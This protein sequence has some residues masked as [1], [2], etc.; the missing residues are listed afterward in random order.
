[1]GDFLTNPTKAWTVRWKGNGFDY[2]KIKDLFSA[3]AIID[4]LTR[5]W[6]RYL[7]CLKVKNQY[8]GCKRNL[9]QAVNKRQEFHEGNGQRIWQATT[10]LRIYTKRNSQSVQ[11]LSSVW[12]FVTPWTAAHQASLSMTNSWCLLKLMSIKS[13]MPSNH[14]ILCHP[15]FSWLQFFPAS[16]SFP[17]SQ[18]FAWGSQ[19]I[20]ATTTASVLPMN[21]QDWFPLGLMYHAP[22]IPSPPAYPSTLEEITVASRAADNVSGLHFTAIVLANH[23]SLTTEVMLGQGFSCL[24][25]D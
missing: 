17:M 9:F 24:I 14:V 22:V 11:L 15:L 2:T 18:F 23:W 10:C 1:M 25:R 7:Q 13:V 16:G 3:V 21:M 4:K 5:G 12:L 8:L 19:S 20:G 6:E